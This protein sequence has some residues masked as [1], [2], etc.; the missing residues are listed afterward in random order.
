MRV[1]VI[2]GAAAFAELVTLELGEAGFAVER[3]R[4]RKSGALHLHE[5]ETA[6]VAG[7]TT[8]R[9]AAHL[10][11]A[12]RKLRADLPVVMLTGSRECERKGYALGADVVLLKPFEFGELCA[13][14]QRLG[15]RRATSS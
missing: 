15:R 12:L 2:G 9:D 8:S 7:G 5:A 13:I 11:G 10:V 1:A 3:L 14:L 4:A 6:L